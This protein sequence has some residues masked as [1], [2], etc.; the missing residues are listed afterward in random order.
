MSCAVATIWVGG[1]IAIFL[2]VRSMLN[3]KARYRNPAA[4]ALAI[5]WPVVTAFVIGCLLCDAV[6]WAARGLIRIGRAKS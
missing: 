3:V 6:E 5:L 2:L 4:I 1:G